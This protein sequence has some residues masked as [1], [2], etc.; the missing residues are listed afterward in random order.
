MMRTWEEIS[1]EGREERNEGKKEGRRM[2]EGEF[3]IYL[4]KQYP[5]GN[6]SCT[7]TNV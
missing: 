3:S 2:E 7:L 4:Y 6:G 1:E 5:K